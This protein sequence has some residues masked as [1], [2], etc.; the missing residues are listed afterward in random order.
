MSL[1]QEHDDELLNNDWCEKVK[2]AGR[3]EKHMRESVEMT[4]E[5]EAMG[6]ATWDELK[7]W[8]TELNSLLMISDLSTVHLVETDQ[9][10]DDLLQ[11]KIHRMLKEDIIESATTE[12]TRSICFAPKKIVCS[13]SVSATKNGTP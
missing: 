12:R 5:I 4:E 9:P 2:I 1:S 7:P 6:K 10:A 8:G 3:Y 11:T 13:D